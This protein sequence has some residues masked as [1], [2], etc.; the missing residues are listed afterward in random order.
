MQIDTIQSDR[1][2]QMLTKDDYWLQFS[3]V[4]LVFVGSSAPC[5][6]ICAVQGKSERTFP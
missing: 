2:K 4:N 6:Y 1:S 3:Q 5:P